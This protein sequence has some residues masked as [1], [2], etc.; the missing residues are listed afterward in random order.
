MAPN[1]ANGILAPRWA[2]DYHHNCD[3]LHMMLVT[4]AFMIILIFLLLLV[5]P[6][7]MILECL[8]STRAINIIPGATSAVNQPD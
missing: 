8:F 5:Q 7:Q 4:D 6:L 1:Y 2:N 3:I